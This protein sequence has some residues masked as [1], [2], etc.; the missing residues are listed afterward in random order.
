M[1]NFQTSIDK[2]SNEK[3]ELEKVIKDAEISSG[4]F[5]NLLTKVERQQGLLKEIDLESINFVE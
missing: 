3:A 2:R 5:K 4:F 1:N